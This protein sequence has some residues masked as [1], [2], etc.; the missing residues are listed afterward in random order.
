MSNFIQDITDLRE[1]GWRSRRDADG[2]KT[3]D[4]I[5]LEV[6]RQQEEESYARINHFQQPRPQEPRTNYNYN[7]F[8]TTKSTRFLTMGRKPYEL[9]TET[10]RFTLAPNRVL[11]N[12]FNRP[13]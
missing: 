12:N 5:H 11:Q 1:S 13:Q 8:S 3:I 10:E 4:E 7:N 2:P 6:N 9:E